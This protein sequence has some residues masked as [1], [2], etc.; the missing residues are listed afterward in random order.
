MLRALVRLDEA[1]AN[2]LVL[3]RD[4]QW[5]IQS[6]LRSA[7]LY[8]DK[9]DAANARRILDEV[10]LKSVAERKER[11][12]LRGRVELIFHRPERAI[13]VFEAL[14]IRPDGSANATLTEYVFGTGR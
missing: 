14:L 9:G 8:I 4:K 13:G 12:L 6:Q 5:G 1:L 10:Q 2:I 7:E 11:R 3:L